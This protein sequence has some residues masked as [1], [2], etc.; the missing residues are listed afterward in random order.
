[1]NK[2]TVVKLT[3]IWLCLLLSAAPAGA[4]AK[5]GDDARKAVQA[6]FDL[7]KAKKYSELYDYL[8]GEMQKRVTRGQVAE[9]LKRLDSFIIIERMEIGR[10]QRRSVGGDEFAVI[11]TTLYGR[12]R[13]PLESNGQKLEA[14]KVAV[15]QYLF[16]EGPHWKVATADGK[17]REQFLKRYPEFSKG[18]QFTQ[19]QF[20][21]KRNGQWKAMGRQK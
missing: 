4:Q 6:F 19:P 10:V 14:G 2:T 20:F 11:D 7:L 16:K 3:I 17:T 15:Q 18:F 1:M 9:G 5:G 12:L 8:P 21:I 13:N